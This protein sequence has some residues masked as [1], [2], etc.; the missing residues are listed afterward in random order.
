[1]GLFVYLS[2]QPN[3]SNVRQIE[4]L[5]INHKIP[6]F[7]LINVQTGGLYTSESMIG[8]PA[9]INFWA[10]WCLPCSIEMP[11]LEELHNAYGE[12]LIMIGINSGENI[13]SI[14]E[15]LIKYDISFLNLADPD[16]SVTALFHVQG[17]PSTYFFDKDGKLQSIHIGQLSKNLLFTY[18][19]SLGIEK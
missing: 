13:S 17:F 3:K 5:E 7:S 12:R 15:Y 6:N 8:K 16:E 18:V 11:L 1:M 14:K 10:T 9:I 2:N 4:K 19:K